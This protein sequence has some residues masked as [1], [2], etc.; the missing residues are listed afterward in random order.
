MK[1]KKL[2]AMLLAVTMIAASLSACGDKP[3]DDTSNG[4]SNSAE[5]TD[6]TP[7]G[8]DNEQADVPESL[9]EITLTFYSADGQAD[10]WTD[11]VA[12]A[13]TAA[14]GVKLDTSYPLSSEE[15]D[16]ALM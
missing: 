14:T 12:L 13:I 5:N 9:D 16:I 8:T 3:N 6:G 4:S 10:P 11:P 2:M 15:E 7:S 1:K